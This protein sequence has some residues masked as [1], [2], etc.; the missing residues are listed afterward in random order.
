MSGWACENCGARRGESWIQCPECR[1]VSYRLASNVSPIVPAGSNPLEG[2]ADWL[3][4]RAV[5]LPEWPHAEQMAV[6][7]SDAVAALAAWRSVSGSSEPR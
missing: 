7:L 3:R 4:D 5:E 1:H 2:T 6:P